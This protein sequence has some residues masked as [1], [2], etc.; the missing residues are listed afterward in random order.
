ML[1]D[2]CSTHL[3][4]MIENVQR[5]AAL[6]ITWAYQNTS[7]GSLLKELSLDTLSKRRTKA[8]LI[9]LFKMKNGLTPD[10]LQVLLPQKVGDC[11]EYFTRNA[12]DL[13]L[14]KISKNYFL[15]SFLPSSI[16]SWNNLDVKTRQS[17]DIEHFRTSI[18]SLITPSTLYRPY[19]FGDRKGFIQ[20]SRMRMGLS[21]LNS[22]RKRY[23]FIEQSH[24]PNCNSKTEDPMH[25]LLECPAYAALRVDMIANLHN[26]IPTHRDKLQ[27]LNSKRARKE[28]TQLLLNGIK[29]EQVDIKIFQCVSVYIQNSQR[30]L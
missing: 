12:E 2:N 22:H 20:I 30:L 17:T 16:K 13:R 11:V 29:I 25:F 14:P 10:Y 6:T 28:L 18:S 9:L 19:L 21:G 24:C 27:N 15:K 26:I 1:F 7:H 8:K 23:H 3:S 5:Q 4:D